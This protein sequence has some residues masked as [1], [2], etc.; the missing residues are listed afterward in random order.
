MSDIKECSKCKGSGRFRQNFTN[1]N[2]MCQNCE[3]VGSV[4]R[5]NICLIAHDLNFDIAMMEAKND[6]LTEAFFEMKG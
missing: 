1:Y 3:G 2:N 4:F 5:D 6:I